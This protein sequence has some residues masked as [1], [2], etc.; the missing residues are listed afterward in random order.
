M[1]NQVFFIIGIIS[2]ILIILHLLF[3]IGLAIYEKIINKTSNISYS[4]SLSK[5]SLIWRDTVDGFYII[6]TIIIS[7]RNNLDISIHWLHFSMLISYEI[8]KDE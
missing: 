6:P 2:V 3:L 4:M 8:K 1:I 7:K 5:D